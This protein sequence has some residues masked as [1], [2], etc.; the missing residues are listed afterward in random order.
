M[1]APLLGLPKS[2]YYKLFD[3]LHVLWLYMQFKSSTT[4]QM[5][6]ELHSHYSR[7]NKKNHKLPLYFGLVFSYF[8]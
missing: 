2:I 7:K 4:S 8:S 3:W 6:N 1:G 5:S